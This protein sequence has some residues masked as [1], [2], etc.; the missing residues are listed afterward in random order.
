MVK[1]RTRKQ[2][3]RCA[4]NR[5]NGGAL[6][7]GY[8]LGSEMLTRGYAAIEP[9]S[10]CGAVARPGMMSTDVTG[11][12]TKGLPGL[13]GGGKRNSRRGK[14]KGKSQR[15]GRYEAVMSG[16]EFEAMGPRGG[17]MATAGRMPCE[18]GQ[19]SALPSPTTITAPLLKGGAQ[20]APAPFLQEQTAGYTQMPSKFLDSVG[21]PIQLHEPVGGRMGT[22]ACGQTGGKRNKKQRGGDACEEATAAHDAA[23]NAVDAAQAALNAAQDVDSSSAAQI[24]L[25]TANNNLQS[26]MV[27]M[28]RACF[29]PN[30]NGNVMGGR[31]K[32]KASRKNRKASR[33]ASRKNRKASRKA[34]RKNRKASRKASRK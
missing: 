30:P 20:L 16:A 27:A 34:S 14:R 4:R 9:Y 29:T 1:Q 8:H 31:R 7:Q 10:T 11:S 24:V 25:D 28:E 26:A 32:G 22:P 3:T 13:S 21:A 33:K 15:G 6:G 12:M 19:G 5:M 18:A 2:R 17:M 23:K